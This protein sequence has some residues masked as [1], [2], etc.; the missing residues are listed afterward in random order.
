MAENKLNVVRRWV[1][2]SECWLKAFLE[3]VRATPGIVCIVVMGSAVRDRGHRRSDFDLLILFRG[4]RLSL[5]P[6]LE[7]DIRMYP[8]G[9]AEE[10]LAAGHEVLGWAMKF[11]TALYDPEGAWKLLRTKFG[12]RVPLPSASDAAK[13]ATQ[14]LLR[15]R[16]MLGIGDESAADDLILAGVT[17]LVRARLI[18]SR[19]FPAS[20]PELPHQ[21]GTIS[22]HDPL[23]QILEDAMFSEVAPADLLHRLA[24]I[25]LA[26]ALRPGL[27]K[28]SA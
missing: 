5:K 3:N 10:N 22:P 1:G 24:Q 28:T 25:S 8:M 27:G 2:D 13:R 16:E 20:R 21:L 14:S 12:D 4:K 7:V 19:I 6:P 26:Q 23:A 9:T 18:K 17:Q 15:A 11:G